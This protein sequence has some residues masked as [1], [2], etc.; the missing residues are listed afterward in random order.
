VR[1]EAVAM[2]HQEFDIL[3]ARVERLERRMRVVVAG[4]V[5]SVAV[6]V[7]LGVAVQQAISQPEVLRARRIE[8]VDAAG[9]ERIG[10]DVNPEGNARMQFLDVR[11]RT[12][13]FLTTD[14]PGIALFDEAGDILLAISL[15]FRGSSPT[16]MLRDAA[17]RGSSSIALSAGSGGPSLTFRDLSGRSRFFLFTSNDGK[18]LLE[19]SDSAERPRVGISLDSDGMPLVSLRD[20]SGLPRLALRLSQEWGPGLFMMNENGRTIFR[21]P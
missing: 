4:W 8:V 9:R 17:A 16:I 6:F 1:E 18:S 14:G 2:E 13:M 15:G 5:L 19:L 12:R 3:R 21:I 10:L 11:G 7:L 20:A